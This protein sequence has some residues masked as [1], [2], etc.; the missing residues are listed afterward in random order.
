MA[1]RQ[2]VMSTCD[3]CK[4]TTL[5]TVRKVQ[6]GSVYVPFGWTQLSKLRPN[7]KPKI[8]LICH[9]CSLIFDDWMKGKNDVGTGAEQEPVAVGADQEGASTSVGQA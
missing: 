9:Q 1:V 7:Q 4:I 5:S 3:R 8:A 2:V 6:P